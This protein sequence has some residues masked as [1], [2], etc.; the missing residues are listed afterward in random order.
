MIFGLKRYFGENS[1]P[2]GLAINEV[3][4]AAVER[5]KKSAASPTSSELYTNE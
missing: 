1:A 2:A 5:G 3:E 4:A